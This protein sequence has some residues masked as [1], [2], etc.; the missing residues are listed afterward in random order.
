MHCRRCFACLHALAALPS[1][2]HGLAFRL[3]PSLASTICHQDQG[4]CQGSE[5]GPGVDCPFSGYHI[6]TFNQITRCCCDL[7]IH[8]CYYSLFVANSD[9]K[10]EGEKRWKKT[11][12][13]PLHTYLSLPSTSLFLH[14][15]AALPLEKTNGP[16]RSVYTFL[17]RS[18]SSVYKARRPKRERLVVAGRD[19]GIWL[20]HLPFFPSLQP[21][22][23]F[24]CLIATV[25]LHIS[26]N[27]FLV[28]LLLYQEE[29]F[30]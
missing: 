10:R 2:S 7:T 1:S 21:L 16:T 29:S 25:L 26:E 15:Q 13:W 4:R 12:G 3:A 14:V 11:R 28:H 19:A 24:S 5:V 23:L 30:S 17:L 18:N 8:I 27:A 6:T 22:P 20:A 9:D